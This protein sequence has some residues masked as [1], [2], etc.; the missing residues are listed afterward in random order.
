MLSTETF[1]IY[2]VYWLYSDYISGYF[3]INDKF[4]YVAPRIA[5][6]IRALL[7]LHAWW[8][9]VSLMN[10]LVVAGKIKY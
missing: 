7:C 2:S 8:A 3:L 9:E 10:G 5:M 4:K 1:S 6:K